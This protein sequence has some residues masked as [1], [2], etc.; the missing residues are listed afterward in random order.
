MRVTSAVLLGLTTGC[1]L[2]LQGQKNPVRSHPRGE[3]A[4]VPFVGCNADGQVG[5]LPPPSGT[6]KEVQVPTSIAGKLAYYKSEA[7]SGVLGPRGWSCFGAYGSSGSALFVAPQP[8]K[9]DPDHPFASINN[10]FAGPVIELEDTQAGGSGSYAVARVLAH[11]FPKL[12]TVVE[13]V[14]QDIP[15]DDE[16]ARDLRIGPYPGDQLIRKGDQIVEF[17]TPPFSEGLGTLGRIKKGQRWIDGVA[18]IQSPTPDLR[19]LKV[20]LPSSME[21]LS[22]YIVQQVEREWNGESAR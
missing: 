8:F 20:R 16:L 21:D 22:N 18:L 19:F 4:S 10:G 14:K 11:A 17:R 15:D 12:K 7:T 3:V 9:M 1:F 6:V 13:G 5:P 2:H